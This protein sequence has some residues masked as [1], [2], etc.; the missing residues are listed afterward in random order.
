MSLKTDSQ[1]FYM[2]SGSGGGE[3]S[4]GLIDDFAV[5]GKAL[6][7]ADALALNS[8]TA[9]SA[10]TG[11]GLIAFWNFNDVPADAPKFTSIVRNANGSVTFTWTGAG[12]LQAASSLNGPWADQTGAT[13]PA[14][15]TVSQAAQFAR[16]IQ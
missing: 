4:H 7:E 5:F 13:S 9:P 6:T 11:K 16:I 10:L 14:T 8:G 2:G 12:K 1:A 15:V 3:Q